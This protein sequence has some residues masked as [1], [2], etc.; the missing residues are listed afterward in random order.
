MYWYCITQVVMTSLQKRS[1]DQKPF[2]CNIFHILFHTIHHASSNI[3]PFFRGPG[4]AKIGRKKSI[5]LTMWP[6]A[7]QFPTCPIAQCMRA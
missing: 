4:G 5:V 3:D 2:S 1:V 6:S 7:L